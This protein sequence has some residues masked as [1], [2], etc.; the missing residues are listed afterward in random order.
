MSNGSWRQLGRYT[1]RW[2]LHRKL[3]LGQRRRRMRQLSVQAC[4]GVRSGCSK[5]AGV[6]QPEGGDKLVLVDEQE[7]VPVE[8]G[9]APASAA[10]KVETLGEK[11]ATDESYVYEEEQM[12][13][14]GMA[15]RS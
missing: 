3:G 12:L 11:A 8:V 13:W 7:E 15:G 5:L 1:G 6:E 9:L 14:K 10:R 4:K 2:T